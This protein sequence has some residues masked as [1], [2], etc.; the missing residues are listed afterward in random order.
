MA[1]PAHDSD[2]SG[3]APDFER[4]IDTAPALIHTSLPDG[5]LDFFNQSWLEYVGRPL[6][7]LQGWK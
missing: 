7:D 1:S 6:E 3:P 2:R 4:L 5:Y